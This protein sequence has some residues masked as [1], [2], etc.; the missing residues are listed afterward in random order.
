MFCCAVP[1]CAWVGVRVA[2]ALEGVAIGSFALTSDMLGMGV[3][4]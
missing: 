3:T 1:F 4:A 2:Q